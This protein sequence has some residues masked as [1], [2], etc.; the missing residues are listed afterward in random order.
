MKK[1]V[2]A[3]SLI[4]ILIVGVYSVAYMH[5]EIPA[6]SYTHLDVYKRQPTACR[7]GEV[8]TGRLAPEGCPLFGKLCTPEDPVGPCMVSSEGACAAAYKYRE[9]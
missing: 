4:A 6:V 2:L 7:C 3:V 5:S 9:C 1:L 8:I